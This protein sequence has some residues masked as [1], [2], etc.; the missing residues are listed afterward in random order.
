MYNVLR[1]QKAGQCNKAFCGADHDHNLIEKLF[2]SLDDAR[3]WIKD[4]HLDKDFQTTRW[5]SSA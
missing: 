2:D 1:H 4:V 3:D 5:E